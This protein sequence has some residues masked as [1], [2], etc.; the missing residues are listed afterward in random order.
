[1]A[2]HTADHHL[3]GQ[4]KPGKAQRR[5]VCTVAM[6]TRAIDHKHF[7][8]RI[9]S[10]SGS[11]YLAVWDVDCAL[12]MALCESIRPAYIYDNEV[13]IGRFQTFVHIPAIGLECEHLLEVPD[14]QL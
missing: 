12:N 2:S 1:P 9:L 11:R 6:R 4:S 14:G 5:L 7:A 8:L 13:V 3:Y 10:H